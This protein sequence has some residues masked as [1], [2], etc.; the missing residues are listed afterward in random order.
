MKTKPG[1]AGKGVN[2][3]K[4][5]A[6]A[7][8]NP[9]ARGPVNRPPRGQGPMPGPGVRPGQGRGRGPPPR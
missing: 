4:D 2:L 6:L 1:S 5:V 7:S 3:Q 9:N 8:P